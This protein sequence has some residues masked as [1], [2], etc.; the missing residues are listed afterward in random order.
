M[1][2]V[3]FSTGIS[4]LV[5]MFIA[6]VGLYYSKNDIQVITVTSLALCFAVVPYCF[7]TAVEKTQK[8]SK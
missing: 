5:A 4:S 3:W 2:I 8:D 1:R 6:L 7:A